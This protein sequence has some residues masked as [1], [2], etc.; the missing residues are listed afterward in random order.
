MA[1]DNLIDVVE[2]PH[3]ARVGMLLREV[4]ALCG[5][6]DELQAKG[7][8][9]NSLQDAKVAATRAVA[10]IEAYALLGDERFGARAQIQITAGFAALR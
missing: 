9:P 1:M 10:A 8:N 3:R 7:L 6:A 4:A 2:R 5:A